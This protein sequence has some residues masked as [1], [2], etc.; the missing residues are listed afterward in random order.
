MKPTKIDCKGCRVKR[1]DEILGC[2]FETRNR[3]KL[4]PC[5]DCL[6]K[7]ICSKFCDKRNNRRYFILKAQG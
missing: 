7:V 6:V 2:I 5:I 4:C 3:I 1:S